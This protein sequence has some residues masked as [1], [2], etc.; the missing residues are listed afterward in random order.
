M[1]ISYSIVNSFTVTNPDTRT[2]TGG[3]GAAVIFMDSKDQLTDET[4]IDIAKQF[5]KLTEAVFV[6]PCQQGDPADFGMR[7]W[8]PQ[9][10]CEYKITGHPTIAAAVAMMFHNHKSLTPD[11][12]SYVLETK[13]GLVSLNINAHEQKVYMGQIQP[14][15]QDIPPDMEQEIHEMF[16]LKKGEIV[17]PV[18]AV[19]MG[20]GY[21]IFKV[22]NLETL[23]RMERNL[24]KLIEANNRFG[25]NGGAQPYADVTSS[26][27][28]LRTRNLD[29]RPPAADGVWLEDTAC[30]QGSASLMA[31]LMKYLN[32]PGTRIRMEQGVPSEP[33]CVEAFGERNSD[34]LE[35]FIGGTAI[36]KEQGRL[37]L[38]NNI[39]VT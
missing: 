4:Q 19:N 17:T 26:S 20:L 27:Y 31:Y 18:K 5:P 25:L 34:K 24:P 29:L 36:E 14:E 12:V 7:Y 6:Y 23:M 35:I 9:R 15:F 21:F 38:Q 11:K 32:H 22:K 37:I 16:G 1:E 28:D 30:G 39:I 8:S 10:L 33:C 3:N 2:Q 13:A